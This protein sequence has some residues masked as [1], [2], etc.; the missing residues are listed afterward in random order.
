MSFRN[1]NGGVKL[2]SLKKVLMLIGKNNENLHFDPAETYQADFVD[3]YKDAFYVKYIRR[4]NGCVGFS[5]GEWKTKLKS[6]DVIISIDSIMTPQ[7]LQWLC[8]QK[9]SARLILYYRNKMDPRI[10][11]VEK[12]KK[13]PLEIWSYNKHDCEKYG[14]RYNCETGNRKLYFEYQ[15]GEIHYSLAFVGANKGREHYLDTLYDRIQAYQ[16]QNPFFYMTNADQKKWNQCRDNKIITYSQYMKI[17]S[18]STCILDLVSEENYGLTLRAVEAIFL[19]KKLVTNYRDIV[20]YDLYDKN[21]IFIIDEDD[22]NTFGDFIRSPY[23]EIP[24]TIVESYSTDAWIKRFL[25]D[26]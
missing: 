12:L 6:Y 10:W 15:K 17:L 20:D 14:F 24:E 13:M 25:T 2:V 5:L 18:Q 3:V 19:K 11:N 9:G 16:L 21:N 23:K 8:A 26:E 1:G 4:F 22:W 7:V